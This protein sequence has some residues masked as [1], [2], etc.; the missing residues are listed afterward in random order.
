MTSTGG[1]YCFDDDQQTPDTHTVGFEFAGKKTITWEGLSCAPSP[2]GVKTPD[3]V[4]YGTKGSLVIRGGSYTVHDEKGKAIREVKGGGGDADHI[5][6]FLAAVRGD[7]KLNSEIE[8]GH[9][10]TLLCHLGNI[11]YRVGR[12]L[13]CDPK[14]GKVVGDKD[15]LALWSREYAK[16]WEPTAS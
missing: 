13:T 5:D 1:R 2:D 15:A 16:G 12:A 10:S 11:S 3:V 14:D 6:N 7:A 9:V 4:F 8:E